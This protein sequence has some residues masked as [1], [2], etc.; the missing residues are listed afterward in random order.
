VTLLHG[1]ILLSVYVTL[2][3]AA[4]FRPL[5]H[6]VRRLLFNSKLKTKW[7]EAVVVLFNIVSILLGGSEENKETAQSAELDPGPRCD[8]GT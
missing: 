3:S 5:Y 6:R 7:K 8:S 4:Q 1:F 2:L